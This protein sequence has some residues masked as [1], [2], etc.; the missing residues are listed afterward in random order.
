M[1]Q[2]VKSILEKLKPKY[3]TTIQIKNVQTDSN[4]SKSPES[5][6]STLAMNSKKEDKGK[7]NINVGSQRAAS[8]Q[9]QNSRNQISQP[10]TN[11]ANE[12]QK[13]VRKYLALEIIHQN[14]RKS[15]KI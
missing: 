7:Q 5:K 4:Q 6:S 15:K 12:L 9:P 3:S 13:T 11:K 10:S 8:Q 14:Y 2:M 1:I